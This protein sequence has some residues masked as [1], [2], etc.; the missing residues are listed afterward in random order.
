[1]TIL[2]S[3]L[4]IARIEGC[5][6]NRWTAYD[7]LGRY[8]F[9]VERLERIL[10]LD[11][12]GSALAHLQ[13]ELA[14]TAATDMLRPAIRE[15]RANVDRFGRAIDAGE[16]TLTRAFGFKLKH[17]EAEDFAKTWLYSP[18]LAA[19][20]ASALDIATQ[21][22][23]IADQPDHLQLTS[24][25]AIPAPSRRFELSLALFC[26]H[27]IKT[28]MTKALETKARLRSSVAA[29]AVERYRLLTGDWPAS[30]N[31]IPTA[32]LPEVPIDPFDGKPLKLAR[33][34]DGVTIY[35]VGRNGT[36]DGGSEKSDL[37]FRLFDPNQ[38]RLPPLTEYG[39]RPR[40]VSRE[41]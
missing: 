13:S 9:V 15:E 7:R 21:L 2:V 33:R 27:N 8:A 26:S 28:V 39:P 31:V 37:V 24:I 16:T 6:P 17:G 36:D 22:L 30:L 1:M 18:R 40:I 20:W 14:K 25:A 35:S 5:A 32:I 41:P 3:L 34:P 19:D 29:I 12:A 4:N 10:A 38:R 23:A 11:R